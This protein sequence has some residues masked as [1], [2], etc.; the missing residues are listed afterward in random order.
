M[1]RTNKFR[2]HHSHAAK[3][4]SKNRLSEMVEYLEELGLTMASVDAFT[5]L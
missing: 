2:N 5:I 1:L 3:Y 4:Q